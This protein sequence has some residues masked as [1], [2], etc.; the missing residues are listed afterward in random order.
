LGRTRAGTLALSKDQRGLRIEIDPPQW[1][2]SRLESIERGD[3]TGMSFGFHVLDDEWRD[4]EDGHPLRLVTDMRVSEV[5]IV[6]FPAY[7]QT[8]VTVAMRSLDAYRETVKRT[9]V[10]WLQKVHKTRLAR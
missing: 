9:S 5:S 2:K 10:A 6:T 4:G 7:Q 1:A 3:V 8:D